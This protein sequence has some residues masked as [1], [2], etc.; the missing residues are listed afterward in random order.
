MRAGWRRL[1]GNKRGAVA[2]TV[3]LSLFALIG[4]GGIAFDY[5]RMASLDTELQNAADQAALAA[6]AQLDGQSGACARAAAAASSL[7]TNTTLFA[8]ETGARAITVDNEGDCDATDNIRFYKSYDQATDT[9]GDAATTDA[10]AKVVIVDVNPRE[11]FFA[12]TP[13][14]AAIRSGSLDAE[15]VASLGTA[16][17]KVPPVMIC[18]PAEPSGNTNKD[19]AF[20]PAAYVGKGLKLVSVGNSNGA[21]APG[22]FGYLDTGSSVSNPNVELRQA[23]GWSGSPGDC[24]PLSGVETRTGAGTSVTPALNTRFDIYE[25]V[26]GGETADSCP[27]G[28]ICPPSINATKDVVRKSA[29]ANDKQCAV[30]N[31]SEW[32]LPD[33]QYLPTS[34]T[35]DLPDTTVIDAMGHPRDKC[36]AVSV[37]GSCTPNSKIGDGNWDRNAYFRV[38]YGWTAAQWPGFINSGISPITT[39]TPTRYQVYRWEIANRDTTI[40]GKTI[41]PSVGGRPYGSPPDAKI[42]FDQ[43]NCSQLQ[44]YGGG[45]VPGGANVDRRRISGAVLNCNAWNVHGGGGTVYPVLKWIELFLVEPSLNRPRTDANDVYVEVISETIAG[46][47]N[48]TAAQVVRRDV[49]YLIK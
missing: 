31:N 43:P 15:A 5:A 34:P 17:C 2:P 3:A 26:T 21:W 24:S 23:L 38:N 9:P 47:G 6:A 7:L 13:I 35:A 16:I 30:M 27:G 39:S 22:N 14:V 1:T 19:L 45:I 20:D 29:P 10:E 32:Q 44:G 28:G 49:P 37:A 40:G 11:A 18:N 48:E 25:K 33:N 46:G 42:D 4:V 41:L 36:H 12:L 8:N